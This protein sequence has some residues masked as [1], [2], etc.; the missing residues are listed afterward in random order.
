MEEIRADLALERAGAR[1]DQPMP[2]SFD[3]TDY[4]REL[5][6]NSEEQKKI[7]RKKLRLMRACVALLSV[8]CAVVVLSALILVPRVNNAVMLANQ[9]LEALQK[10]DVV[11][12]TTNIDALTQQAAGYVSDRRG[13]G[14]SPQHAR[15][16]YP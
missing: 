15:Y 8:F 14:A 16:G 10:V 7:E 9:T 1:A 3:V 4:V 11:S 13:V 12:I 5:F 2:D 6:L